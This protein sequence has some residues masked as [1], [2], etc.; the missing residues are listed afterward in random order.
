MCKSACIYHEENCIM[1]QIM[2]TMSSPKD[3][4]V[5]RLFKIEKTLMEIS[6]KSRIGRDMPPDFKVCVCLH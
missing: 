3:L 1:D 6:H 4:C 2:N 5:L